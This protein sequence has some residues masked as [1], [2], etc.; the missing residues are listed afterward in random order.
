[1]RMRRGV[2]RLQQ[3]S[4]RRVRMRMMSIVWRHGMMNMNGMTGIRGRNGMM[5][6]FVPRRRRMRRGGHGLK[7]FGMNRVK[8]RR[9]LELFD[10][11]GFGRI[12]MRRGMRLLLNGMNRIARRMS[13][14]HE[15]AGN[16]RN[17][18]YLMRM[19]MKF[20][21]V[22]NRWGMR[23]RNRNYLL[24]HGRF[25]LNIHVIHRMN[26]YDFRKPDHPYVY[27]K[28]NIHCSRSLSCQQLSR[29]VCFFLRL[30]TIKLS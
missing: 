13:M 7:L 22:V 6:F 26:G 24:R 15:R 5:G 21:A 19:R 2:L 10:I 17:R 23:L 16:R 3:R 1:M 14:K 8:L 18:E 4:E 25:R 11:R 27:D 9:R 12:R 20:N 30:N 29:N 28:R